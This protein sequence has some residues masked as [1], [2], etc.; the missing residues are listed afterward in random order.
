LTECGFKRSF[1][2]YLQSLGDVTRT[3]AAGADFDC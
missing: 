1:A 3:D 2:V